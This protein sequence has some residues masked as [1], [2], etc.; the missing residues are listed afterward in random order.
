MPQLLE[1]ASTSVSRMSMQCGVITIGVYI[2]VER[3][4]H[5]LRHT[6]DLLRTTRCGISALI[7]VPTSSSCYIP[8]D[9]SGS[10]TTRGVTGICNTLHD[11]CGV[12]V[13]SLSW[14]SLFRRRT[15]SSSNH[16]ID[17]FRVIWLRV[18]TRRLSPVKK[19]ESIRVIEGP[20]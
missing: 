11:R 3:M 6:E 4:V 14:S 13:L 19:V 17:R 2:F 15:R 5:F 10:I 20:G 16:I 7:T 8:S 18:Y 12:H 9:A 1:E